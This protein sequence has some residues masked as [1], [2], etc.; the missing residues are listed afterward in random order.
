MDSSSY[1]LIVDD[2]HSDLR[3]LESILKGHGFRPLSLTDPTKVLAQCRAQPPLLI[4]LDISMPELDGFEVCTQLKADH[5]LADIPVLFLT[6]MRDMSDRLRG[7]K[8]GGAD[9]LTKPYEPSEL[10]ARVSTHIKLRKTQ[11]ELA[12]RNQELKEK[13]S[14][15][16]CAHAAL[17]ESQART[18]AVLNNAGICI[19][20]LDINCRYEKV[21][22]MYARIF[23]YSEEE[24]QGMRL[25]DI[26][27]PDYA[28]QSQA[29][30]ERLR[31]GQQE[32]HYA[33]KVFV[34][35]NGSQFPGGHWLSPQRDSDG[36]CRGFV[37]VISDLTEQKEAE[38]KLRLAHTVFE[39]SSEG[40]LITDEDNRI[41]MVNPAFTAIT[42]WRSEEVIG[43]T[44]FFQNSNRHS[45]EFYRQMWDTLLTNDRWQGELW[46]CRRNGEV[47]PLWL[48]ISVIR[49][50]DGGIV[51]HVALFSDISERKKA[52]EILRYQAMH[53]PLTKLP[54]RAMF[55]ER[56]R[57]ALARARRKQSL[58]ALLYLDLDNFKT[59]NDTLGHAAGDRLLQLVAETMQ[60]CLRV[61]DMAARIG[62]DEFCAILEDI[63]SVSHAAGIAERII[64]SLGALDCSP[65]GY[66]LRT[67]I[68][69]AVYPH[70]GEDAEHLLR[71]ADKAMYTAKR[72]GKGRCCLAAGE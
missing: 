25:W 4:L 46:N 36:G 61:E 43:R 62:G 34:R 9:F 45:R 14:D 50:Q 38:H 52:E 56:L 57:G 71:C 35:K 49:G 19:G 7:F 60:S 33:D 2:Q 18:N 30:A 64:T 16:E 13:I 54:N 17:L 15:L 11:L 70:H 63:C 29:A 3:L 51:N 5:L 37:C 12:R 28:E 67:S 58:V 68:G 55:D 39:T 40:M 26:L 59:V 6:S 66:G 41:V 69:I 8:A 22:G 27:R 32:Q 10:I 20:V 72:L 23:G 1:V 47:Y 24:F 53:D 31:S 21:N 65:D 48:S 44:P 42:G